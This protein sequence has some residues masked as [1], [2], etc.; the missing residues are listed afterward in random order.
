[1][2]GVIKVLELQERKK[3]EVSGSREYM[4]VSMMR[5]NVKCLIGNERG[6]KVETST[7]TIKEDEEKKKNLVAEVMRYRR[8]AS[9]HRLSL[10]CTVAIILISR[11]SEA[12]MGSSPAVDPVQR[13]DPGRRDREQR[14]AEVLQ[15]VTRGLD[16]APKPW[17]NRKRE[18]FRKK[19]DY[20]KQERAFC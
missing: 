17:F 4:H 13:L 9:V 12:R 5:P 14:D 11:R 19:R 20:T 1:M 16:A 7:C 10:A 18:I 6:Y 8:V 2:Y 3:C 15:S